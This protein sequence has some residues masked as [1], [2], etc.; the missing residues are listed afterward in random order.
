MAAKKTR[1]RKKIYDRLGGHGSIV[2]AIDGLYEGIL[3]DSELTGF[4][5]NTDIDWLKRQQVAFVGSALGGPERYRG[6]SMREAHATLGI[7]E[8]HFTKVAGHL[9]AALEN[10]GVDDK[11]IAEVIAAV[12][13]LAEDIVTPGAAARRAGAK[14]TLNFQA[15]LENAPT[16]VL[17]ANAPSFVI[18]YAN[19]ASIATLRQLEA[20]LPITAEQIFGQNIDIFHKDPAHQRRILSDPKNLPHRAEIKLGP[21]TLDLLVTAVRDAQGRYVGAMVTWEIIT[22]KIRIQNELARIQNMMENAPS[23]VLFANVRDFKIE[24]ANP[25]S[26]H[27]L[28]KLEKY[29]PIKAEQIVGQVVDIF[30]KDPAHQRRILSD[31]TNLPHRAQIALGPESLDLLVTA[32]NDAQGRYVGAMV[33][34]EVIT[35]RIEIENDLARIRNMMENAP[36]NV[37]FANVEDFTIEYANPASVNTLKKLEAYLPIKGEQIVGQVIDIFHRDPAHQRR[38]VSDSK[39]LPHRAQIK[40]GPETLDLLVTAVNDA[41]GRY[42]GAMV[43]WE[44]IS[45]RLRA[46]N[47]LGR[48]RNM[49]E[50]APTNVM[51]ADRDNKIQYMNP[52]S[53]N[54]LKSLEKDLPVKADDMIGTSID[55]FHVDPAYQRN[56]LSDAQN[57]P[58]RRNIKVGNETLDLLVSAIRDGSGTYVGAMVTWEIISQRLRL[59]ADQK[60]MQERERSQAEELRAKVDELLGAVNSAAGGDL[61]KTVSVRGND[62]IGQVGESLAR[63][64][65]DLRGNIKGISEQAEALNRAASALMSVSDGM[66]R[67]AEETSSQANAVSSASEQVTRNVEAVSGGAEELGASIREIADNAAQAARVANSAVSVAQS[68]NT[69]VAKLGESSAEIGQVI[70]VITSIAQQTNLLA[71]N[72]TIEAARAGEAGKGFAVVANEVKELAKETAR[73][74]EDISRRIEAI[75]G[76]TRGA[77]EGIGEITEV[78]NQ[79]N[80]LQNTIAS[81]VEQQTATTNEISRSVSEAASGTSEIAQNISSV[82]GAADSTARGASD[83]RKA[84]EELTNMAVRL[85]EVVG[86]FTY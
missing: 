58:R 35:R 22:E 6:R 73:A 1:A 19:P 51:F 76:D 59:E 74:T 61:T 71:L 25:A 39:N 37:L 46:E 40:L 20:H 23:N 41:K 72:A 14:S 66:T 5:A 15:M 44:V 84:S 8:R 67:N 77:V 70:K 63:F 24:Y 81:S 17:Y 3:A 12:A 85:R 21:E 29:L 2:A 55:L 83:T 60:A 34:W 62:P 80:E 43:T 68:T 16:N 50:N 65:T 26:V 7:R 79:I 86:R 69:T 64:L 82:A 78:I 54:T 10:L 28:R 42:V 56:L 4:F 48:I 9:T 53:R 57:L 32:V 52:A 38:I 31:P 18:E 45:D 30:H 75:Q 13:P 27:T 11:L 33:T 36:S 49:M 47:E